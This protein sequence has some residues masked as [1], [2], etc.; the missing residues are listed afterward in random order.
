MNSKTC[1]IL[2]SFEFSLNQDW[3]YIS[4]VVH[5]R[6]FYLKAT[7]FGKICKPSAEFVPV[8]QKIWAL[9]FNLHV[10]ILTVQ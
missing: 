10:H 1:K 7:E 6:V 8:E 3:G 2:A 9:E 5:F 4:A